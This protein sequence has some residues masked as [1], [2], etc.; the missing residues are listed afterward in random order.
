MSV[1]LYNHTTDFKYVVVL[2]MN[3]ACHRLSVDTTFR[4][5]VNS[6]EVCQMLLW[7]T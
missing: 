6:D 2:L 1:G 3:M 7:W 4:L 5:Y